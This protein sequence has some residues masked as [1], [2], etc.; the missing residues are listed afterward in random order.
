MMIAVS[1]FNEELAEIVD[2]IRTYGGA[3]AEKE[4][5]PQI[6]LEECIAKVAGN[7]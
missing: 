2:R 1:V 7:G 3:P 6:D 4:V 5:S